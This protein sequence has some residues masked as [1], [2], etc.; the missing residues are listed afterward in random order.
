MSRSLIRIVLILMCL[1]LVPVGC[2]T[3]D[4]Y[5]GER[6]ASKTTIGAAAGAAGGAAIGALT[7]G[8][9][10]RRALYGAAAGALAGGAV[11]FYMDRQE[12][13]LREQLQRTGVSVTRNGDQIILN[14]PGNVTFDTDSASVKPQFYEVLDSVA[15][16]LNEYN[17]T[18][19]DVIGHT[20]STGSNEYNQRLSEERAQSVATYLMGRQVNA[21][22]FVIRGAG[23]T[24]PVADNASPDGRALNRRVEIY[25]TP[26]THG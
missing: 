1:T 20:D 12:A 25:L 15:L 4:P 18:F 17:K 24:Q 6:K 5:T 19:V 7:G 10:G 14:M 26:I 21:D 3:T 16:V 2:A 22:R 11:G 9:R 8:K 13:K 23:E